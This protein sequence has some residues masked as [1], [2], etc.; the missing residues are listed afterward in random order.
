MTAVL[1]IQNEID[2]V[3]ADIERQKHAVKHCMHDSERMHQA[4]LNLRELHT[5]L[6]ELKNN[7][8]GTSSNRTS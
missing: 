8:R 5:R 1:D 3:E 4:V 7:L 6:A 2:R